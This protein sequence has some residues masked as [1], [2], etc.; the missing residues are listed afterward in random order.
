[1]HTSNVEIVC[2]PCSI[3]MEVDTDALRWFQLVSDGVTVTEVAELHRVSQ[4]GVSRAL[5]RLDQ[6]A[7]AALLHKSGRVLRLTH[8]GAV[9]KRHVDALIHDLDDGL[10]AVD[11]LLDPETGT[12][13][14]AFQLSLGTWLVPE[15][16]ATFRDRYPRIQFRLEHSLDEQ[17]SSAVAGGR[18]D[19]E[20][21]SRYPRN[22]DV[23]WERVLSQP[24]SLAVPPGHRLARRREVA[25]GEAADED[26]VMLRPTWQLRARCEELCS[27]A[28]F[29]PRV[30]FEGDD[31]TVVHGLVSAGLGV[32][33]VPEPTARPTSRVGEERLLRLNDEGADREIG[34]LWSRERRLLPSAELF[35]QH[36]LA[37]RRRLG[38]GPDR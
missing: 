2:D 8:A 13:S 37:E 3:V 33:I 38:R 27:A 24:L 26:F 30:A 31:L 1:M 18:I 4:P 36:V 7:G 32:S 5:A 17:G 19:L 12:V 23:H 22:P 28:G 15:L 14:V 10:A 29:S 16:I 35:R 11:E 21:T 9:F 34:L 20:L 25:L 6:Q